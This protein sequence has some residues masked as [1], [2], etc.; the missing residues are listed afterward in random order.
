MKNKYQSLCDE[1]NYYDQLVAVGTCV[2]SKLIKNAQDNPI[3]GLGSAIK[4]YFSNHIDPENPVKTV[5][6][7][8]APGIIRGLLPGPL[9]WIVGLALSTFGVDFDGL[10]RSVWDNL[11]GSVGNDQKTSPS[12][13]DT[14]VDSALSKLETTA[15]EYDLHQIN[16][17]AILGIGRNRSQDKNMLGKILKWLFKTILS[18]A[19][20]MVG[21]DMINKMVGRPNAFDNTIQNGKPVDTPSNNTPSI[22]A[23][24]STQTK[25]KVKPGYSDVRQPQPWTLD[26]VNSESNISNALI[27]FSKQVYDGLD[28]LESKIKASPAFETVKDAIVWSNRSSQGDNLVFIPKVFTSKKQLVDFFIDDVAKSA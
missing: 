21:G 16:K 3:Y 10:I 13:V 25:F 4:N 7:F 27:D 1:V 23:T 12:S 28:G 15:Q 24:K 26:I 20:L 11:K 6:N 17:L 18:S 5:V 2:D 14:A 19:G 9:R 8:L 22:P